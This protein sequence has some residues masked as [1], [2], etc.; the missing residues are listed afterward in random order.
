[1][2]RSRPSNW[3]SLRKKVYQRDNHKCQHC[4][5]R[6]G[7]YGDSE[8]HAHHIVPLNKGGSDD[9]SNLTTLCKGCHDSIHT[10]AMAPSGETT[11]TDIEDIETPP[12]LL[13]YAVVSLLF[14]FV[15]FYLQFSY[16]EVAVGWALL[17][18]VPFLF[19]TFVIS[20]WSPEDSE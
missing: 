3:D 11:G 7:S 20:N 14:P 18:L 16:V 9:L 6:G 12:Y 15:G 2:S 17:V 13:H 8:L 10:S 1:M 4:G 5:R 19:Y